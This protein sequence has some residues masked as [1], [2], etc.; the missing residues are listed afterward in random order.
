MSANPTLPV[1]TGLVGATPIIAQVNSAT[2]ASKIFVTL[3]S[4]YN[5]APPPA[6]PD[7][8]AGRAIFV[9]LTAY[10]QT[11]ASGTRLQLFSDEAAALVGAGAAAYS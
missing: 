5:R 4:N 2:L 8:N 6:Y 10:A 9:S 11:I 3:S 1:Q 7:P